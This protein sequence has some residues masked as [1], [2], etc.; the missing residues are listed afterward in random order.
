MSGYGTSVK[1]M[2]Y[3]GFSKIADSDLF[4]IADVVAGA[5]AQGDIRLG[6]HRGCMFAIRRRGQPG[7]FAEQSAER[8]EAL[9]AHFEADFGDRRTRRPQQQFGLLDPALYQILV[10]C[11]FIDV[12]EHAD[13]VIHGESGRAR[14]LIKA[15]SRVKALVYERM[16]KPDTINVSMQR[17]GV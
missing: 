4:G 11:L 12:T 14:Q 1:Q 2:C 13:E 3:R 7:G 6:G 10:R 16:G 17:D 9:E 5:V 15:D 8:A